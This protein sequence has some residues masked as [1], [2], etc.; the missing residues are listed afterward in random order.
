MQMPI[1]RMSGWPWRIPAARRRRWP[2]PSPRHGWKT[3]SI[4]LSARQRDQSLIRE[5]IAE[6]NKRLL[7]SRTL[8]PGVRYDDDKALYT[9]TVDGVVTGVHVQRGT[10]IN[11]GAPLFTM[12]RNT[13]PLEAHV[14]IQ[15]R[16]IG[17]IRRGQKVQIKY[18]A[19]PTQDYGVQTGSITEIAAKPTSEPG[20]PS[21]Y[22]VNVALERETVTGLS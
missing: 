2:K 15:N 21:L 5:R 6:L 4:I 11:P 13:A 18:F 17:K 19:Y 16:D 3:R 10:I 14:M 9:S 8:V 22:L 12:V 1:S 20:K 7:E